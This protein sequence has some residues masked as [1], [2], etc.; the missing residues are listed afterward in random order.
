MGPLELSFMG[1]NYKNKGI[2]II[3][4]KEEKLNQKVFLLFYK[5]F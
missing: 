2:Q 3:K 4:I 5:F 1:I